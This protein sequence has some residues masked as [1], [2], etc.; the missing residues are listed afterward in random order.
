MIKKIDASRLAVGMH[1]HEL[2]CAWL[3]SP[4]WQK[5]FLLQDQASIDKVLAAR[6]KQVWIDT[7]KGLDEP[8]VVA[9]RP[10][11]AANPSEVPAV[12]VRDTEPAALAQE[13][14]RAARIVDKGRD[15]V[16]SMFNEARMG[17]AVDAENA[18]SLVEDITSSVMRNGDALISLARLKRADDYTYM[19]S[20]AVCA[21]MIA[22]GRQLGMDDV[23]IREAG[24]A[25]LFHDIGKMAVPLEILNK[26]GKL[27][28][29]EFVSVRGHPQAGY[30]MLLGASGLS[31]A[32]LDVCLHHHE[33]IDG[34]GYPERLAG[35]A[36]S[37]LARMGA[38][39]DVY[40]AITS[41]RPYKKGWC[42][43]ESL[44]RMASWCPDHL[45]AAIFQSFVKSIGIYPVGTLVRLESG[46]LGVVVEQQVGQS[47]LLP[48][49]RVFFAT[50]S[51]SYITPE[52]IDL[53]APH[54]SDRIAAS[55]VAAKW[56]LKNI[57]RY[58]TGAA[59]S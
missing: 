40:D 21:L 1:V 20:V 52:L 26:P 11:P 44:R 32:I 3:D 13:L 42:P 46:K 58:W 22:L 23:E 48:K 9:A 57:D 17:R 54:I 16:M 12:A 41:N 45:D 28:D 18:I 5:S 34:T 25:G 30:Q 2:C 38:I 6:I 39:C 53:A 29:A 33:K 49:V 31:P 19:H 51:A 8:A 10:A 14:G 27:T 35:D 56:G 50:K 15:A 4:F 36:I 37:V 7:A 47:L 59:A 43:T 24:M 55:E